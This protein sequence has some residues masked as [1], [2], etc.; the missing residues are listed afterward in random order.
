LR[1]ANPGDAEALTELTSDEA[2]FGGVLQMPYPS[3]AARRKRLETEADEA[4]SLHLVA[5]TEERLIASAGIHHLGWS[6]RRR[7]VGGLFMMVAADWQGRGVGSQLMQALL[8]WA[9]NWVSLLR[10]ELTVYTDNDRAI[11]LYEKFGFER[12]GVHRAFALRAGLYVDALAMA[13]LHPSPP[14]SPTAG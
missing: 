7:H 1:R 5:T 12:E 11:H 2:V 4:L 14:L 6:P 8:D 10:I 9:D 3:A 13:R